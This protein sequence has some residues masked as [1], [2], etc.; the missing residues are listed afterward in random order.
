MKFRDYFSN[1]FETSETHYLPEL[2]TRYY[3]CRNDV[4]KEEVL[5]MISEEQGK[6]KAILDEHH[7]IFFQTPTYTSTITI[8][9]THVTETAIEIK[10]TTNRFL[11]FGVGRKIIM[12]LY[13]YLD[14]KLPFKGVSLYK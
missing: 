14:K 2:R 4:A 12:R 1:D 9:S 7:E 13:D 8:I 5:K 10:I 3:R 11:P 6:V